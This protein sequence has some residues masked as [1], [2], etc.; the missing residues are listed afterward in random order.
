MSVGIRVNFPFFLFRDVH[1]SF[2][3][4]Y[5]ASRETDKPLLLSAM[6]GGKDE[7]DLIPLF[8]SD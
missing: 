3:S 6:L 5:M 1:S 7:V 8:F 4:L 2:H